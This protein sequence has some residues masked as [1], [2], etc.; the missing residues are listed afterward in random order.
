V[1][2]IEK[3]V[4]SDLPQVLD[5][6]CEVIKDMTARG[7]EQWNDQYPRPE[8]FEADIKE[9][10]LFAMK[11]R[12]KLIGIIVLTA[13]PFEQYENIEWED[14]NGRHLVGHRIAIHPKWHRKGI[15]NRFMEFAEEYA[16]KNGYSSIRVDT[17]HKNDRSQALIAKR[18]FTRRP[19]HINFPECNGPYF[20]YELVL[21]KKGR[22]KG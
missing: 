1:L 17:Y 14:T 18:G 20:C 19:G 22:G 21:S 13:Q 9:G 2:R 12:G 7:N 11:E 15:A 3:A 8:I 16:R 10:T 5:L 6:I 4:P